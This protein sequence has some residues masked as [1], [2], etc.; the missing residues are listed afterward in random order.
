MLSINT[1]LLTGVFNLILV[2]LLF[3]ATGLGDLICTALGLPRPRC[4][5]T[6]YTVA[7]GSLRRDPG[8]LAIGRHSVLGPS[9]TLTAT[10]QPI[11]SG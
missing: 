5:R 11:T 4:T 9:Q 1:D 2:S 7:T 6:C 10:Q 8:G 3:A